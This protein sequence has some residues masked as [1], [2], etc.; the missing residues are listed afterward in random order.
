[1]KRTLILFG[2]IVMGS[3]LAFASS[4]VITASGMSVYLP[5]LGVQS[6][7]ED[8]T[9]EAQEKLNASCKGNIS[10][11]SVVTAGCDKMFCRVTLIATC[12]GGN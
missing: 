11:V 10:G 7:L 6:S 5:Q 12:E 4:R 3:V 9:K 1:M 8:A 2:T